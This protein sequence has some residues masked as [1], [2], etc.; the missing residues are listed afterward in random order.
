MNPARVHA[1]RALDTVSPTRTGTVRQTGG[2]VGLGVGRGVGALVGLGVRAGVGV[3]VG[4]G[5]LGGGAVPPAG[6]WV[7]V[8][9]GEIAAGSVAGEASAPAVPVGL[10]D[11]EPMADKPV[12]AIATPVGEADP[13]SNP[14]VGGNRPPTERTSNAIATTTAPTASGARSVHRRVVAGRFCAATAAVDATAYGKAH[15]GQS[16]DASAQHHRHA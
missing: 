15:P 12:V 9:S 2:G 3:G 13:A 14:A 16:P 7:P 10:P 4:V 11:G 8:G 6:A 1:A 5:M